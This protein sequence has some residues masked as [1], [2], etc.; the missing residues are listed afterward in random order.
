MD[1]NEYRQIIDDTDAC[2]REEA[3]LSRRREGIPAHQDIVGELY[4]EDSEES[5][6]PEEPLYW[7]SN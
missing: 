4:L 2:L 5:Y 7:P 6:F 3:D 1:E